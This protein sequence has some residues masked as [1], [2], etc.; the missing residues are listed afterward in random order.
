MTAGIRP[1]LRLLLQLRLTLVAVLNL[2]RK[3]FSRR[4]TLGVLFVLLSGASVFYTR[5]YTHTRVYAA[6]SNTVNFQARLSGSAGYIV[7]DG[8]YSVVFN[9]Y[10]DP[11]TGT[12]QWTETQ[13]VT[14]KAGY[15]SVYLGSST[16]F[17][18]TI[19]WSQAQYLTMNVNGDGEM[20]PRLKLTAVPYAFRAAQADTLT[21]TGGTVTGDNLVQL[22][23]AGAQ[24]VNSAVAGLRINQVGS[25]GLLQL[26]AGGIDQFTISNTGDVA[27]AGTMAV[28]GAS[29]SVGASGL[30]GSLILSDGSANTVSL[31]A[32]GVGSSYALTMPASAPL[33][34]QCLRAGSVTATD[35]MFSSCGSS[36]VMQTYDA[37]G[38]NQAAT[39]TTAL[40]TILNN[41][42]AT[43]FSTAVAGTTEVRMSRAGSFRSCS[44]SNSAAVTS[45]SV[46]VHFRKNG[47]DVSATNYCTLNTTNTRSN[48]EDIDPGIETF[49]AGDTIGVALVSTALAPITLE[50]RVSF[51]VEFGTGSDSGIYQM[52]DAYNNSSAT[53]LT[54]DSTRGGLT[55]RDN[56]A[57][58]AGNLFE[59]Q[60]NTGATTYFGVTASG[61]TSANTLTISAGG[62]NNTSG[63]ITNTGNLTG[64]GT[65]LT[66]TAGLTISTGGAGDLT[67]D[68]ASNKLVIAATDTTLQR[69]AAGAY[70]I[71][72]VDGADTTLA[73]T[74]TGAG[75]VGMTIEG[76]LSTGGGTLAINASGDMTASF[77]V[78]NGSTTTNGTSGGGASTSMVLTNATNFDIGNYVQITAAN[79]G[80]A[81][82]NTCYAKITAKAVNTLTITP[83]LRWTNGITVTEYHVPEIGATNTAQPLTSRF[84]RGYFITGVATG[85]GT[86]YYNEDGISSSVDTFD[87][88]NTGVA[89]LNIGG[90]AT[91]I[92]LGTGATSVNVAG[93][94]SVAG[95][96]VV[97]SGGALTNISSITGAAGLTISSGGTGDLT[98]DSASNALVIAGTDTTLKRTAAGTYTIDLIDA[99]NTTLAIS[100]SGVGG[101]ATLNLTDGNLAIAG[102]TAIDSSRAANLT[103]ISSTGT[104][105]FNTLSAGGLVKSTGGTLAIA[106]GGTDYELPLT[107][108]SGLTRS[109]N[110]VRLGGSLT[111]ATDIGLN[112]NAL[113]IT[114]SGSSVFTA[115][116]AGGI[117]IR[118]DS[119]AAMAVRN[120]AGTRSYLTVNTTG[121]LIQV[122]SSATDAVAILSILDSYNNATD[123]GGV[124]GGSYYNSVNNKNRC[125]EDGYWSDCN[126][127]GV[128]GETTLGAANGTISVT[129]AKNYEYLECHL[130][131]KSRSLTTSQVYMRFNNV[132][133][134]ASYGW[135]SVYINGVTVA[136][137]QTASDTEIQLSSGIGS[138]APFN[139]TATISNFTDTRKGVEWSANSIEPIGTNLHHYNGSGSFVLAAGQISSVQ[140]ITSGGTFATGSH[141]WCTGRN[142]R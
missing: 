36:K 66:A 101:V 113:T 62:I 42:S 116:A 63:G 129:L 41:T 99:A 20:T 15:L 46:S 60:N 119:T 13:S 50:H 55:I 115:F 94:L 84:G 47:A 61:T 19:D 130:E 83:A 89:T 109:T 33:A 103:G 132:A 14:V 106:T 9:L 8:S 135:N 70:T 127:Q 49:A 112:G 65:A 26:A 110:T 79:C 107:I 1:F 80:G 92:A 58:L 117:D 51:T 5:A 23:P 7:P 25:G 11:T 56:A 17:P 6:P 21:I 76:S 133:T 125:Y 91:S 68:S 100:N 111:Q 87:L 139:A 18:G 90:A 34:N 22:A 2:G 104:I 59:V 37:F 124:N 140:F 93:S 54:L 73:L 4:F 120:A 88:L 137:A 105:Q 86:T 71:D 28:S 118:N 72:L 67:L 85:N 53:E 32:S 45:G 98:L 81:G 102:T 136:D 27:A 24:S 96:S 31:T 131:V 44:I 123:P 141:A 43:T 3:P 39:A 121:N 77:T 82:V 29:L 97:G 64:V 75:L 122:G 128:L 134:A 38:L 78:L 57:P 35:L 114:G 52:Q 30:A 108:T 126:D 95:T 74:N 138:Q 48:T 12:T 142:V 40:G 10:D 16:P 69:T